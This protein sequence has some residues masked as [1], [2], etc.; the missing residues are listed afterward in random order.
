MDRRLTFT[1]DAGRA[2]SLTSATITCQSWV[3]VKPALARRSSTT[4]PAEAAEHDDRAGQPR[5]QL[6]AEPAAQLGR[7]GPASLRP[8]RWPW[9][10]RP[11][12]STW[13]GRPGRTGHRG[14]RGDQAR[15]GRQRPGWPR[16]EA[17]E[18]RERA[19]RSRAAASATRSAGGR[20]AWPRPAPAARAAAQL[21]TRA[22]LAP[23]SRSSGFSDIHQCT[24]LRPRTI[25]SSVTHQNANRASEIPAAITEGSHQ[26]TAV[27]CADQ[28]VRLGPGTSTPCQRSSQPQA[29]ATAYTGRAA[30]MNVTMAPR[31]SDSTPTSTVAPSGAM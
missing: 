29:C 9:P 2:P 25:G 21:T 13:P 19:Q 12:H 4:G 5:Q 20:R 6:L 18:M 16:A 30:M 1:A 22:R 31:S 15:Q 26:P 23:R 28:D 10:G 7:A 24:R 17:D 3:V 14:H 8:R 11:A 27:T